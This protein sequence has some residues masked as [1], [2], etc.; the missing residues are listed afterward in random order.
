MEYHSLLAED[1]TEITCEEYILH[2][3]ELYINGDTLY[4][5]R[6]EI[7]LLQGMS[8]YMDIIRWCADNHEHS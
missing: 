8:G 7:K 4:V 2:S 3:I 6:S 1:T 5:W